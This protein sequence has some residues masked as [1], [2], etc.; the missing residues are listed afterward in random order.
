MTIFKALQVKEGSAGHFESTVV[1]RTIE[2][3]PAG[4]VLIRVHYSSLNFKDALSTIGHPGVTLHYPHTPGVDA[5]GIVVES[6]VP[7]FKAG[8]EVI[9]TGYDLGINTPGGFGQFIRVPANWVIKH[10]KGLTLREAMTLG[11]AGLTA[12]LGVDKLERAGLEVGAGPILVTGATGGVGSVAVALLASLGYSVV[13]AT[14]KVDQSA[15]LFELGAKQVIHRDELLGHAE[16]S[17]L[18]ERWA[19]AID[20]VGG[21]L[22]LGVLKS[23]RRGASVACCGLVG[24]THF[25]ASVWPFILR[26]VNLLGIDAVEA[27]IVAKASMWDKLSVQWK[28]NNLEHLAH[29]IT[30]EQ[31]PHEI[32]KLLAGQQVGRVLINLGA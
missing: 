32:E 31:L 9:V 30:L 26:G 4:E 10:P 25:Q 12:A 29:E 23:L 27:P 19:G 13:A 28:L 6:S 20:T 18:K 16:K 2:E 5:A 21:E 24:G 8:D 7:E 1:E 11:T 22:L 3:L 15:F 17:L 14:G